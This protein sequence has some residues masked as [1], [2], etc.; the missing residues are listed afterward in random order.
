M[1][2]RSLDCNLLLFTFF[3]VT[4][5]GSGPLRVTVHLVKP[6]IV[7][8][9]CLALERPHDRLPEF[10]LLLG[11]N[12]SDGVILLFLRI[13]KQHVDQHIHSRCLHE[14]TSEGSAEQVPT[15]HRQAMHECCTPV[16]V[17]AFGRIRTLLYQQL[18][19]AN[20][21]S[22]ILRANGGGFQNTEPPE[23]EN[24]VHL[25][26]YL[27]DVHGE[28][29]SCGEAVH[30]R[31]FDELHVGVPQQPLHGNFVPVGTRLHQQCGTMKGPS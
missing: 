31:I 2:W 28:E 19:E 4:A 16:R 20:R 14:P 5:H 9:R 26:R 3:T 24:V 23:V 21:H 7:V 8:V 30:N 13:L 27:V 18:D 25:F 1:Q 15:R 17:A 22:I 29:G 6:H 11:C 10:G 12:V